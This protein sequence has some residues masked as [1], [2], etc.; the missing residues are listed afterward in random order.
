MEM[1]TQIRVQNYGKTF[2]KEAVDKNICLIFALLFGRLEIINYLCTN[3]SRSLPVR[4]AYPAGHFYL[5]ESG[6]QIEP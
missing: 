4:L 5:W 1:V 6:I 3:K 2:E